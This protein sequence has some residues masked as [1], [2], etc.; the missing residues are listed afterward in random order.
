MAGRSSR[1]KGAR[2]EREI[3]GLHQPI[4]DEVCDKLG[5]PR[6]VL[7]RNAD[8]R[9]A[10]KQYDLI[11]VPW[12]AMEVKRVENLSGRGRWWKQT[13]DATRENQ[14]PALFYRPNHYPW[15]VRTRLPI[16]V[17]K[18]SVRVRSTME[19]DMDS[20]LVFFKQKLLAEL[21]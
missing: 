20:W 4:V 12:I 21:S 15:T 3:I 10:K 11:G 18:G 9:F 19:L 14:I 13:L 2:G 7:R 6:L 17:V 8:Q 16:S 1:N 5:Q